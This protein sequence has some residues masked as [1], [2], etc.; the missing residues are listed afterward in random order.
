MHSSNGRSLVLTCA[1]LLLALSACPR[2]N[3]SPKQPTL[4]FQPQV[5]GTAESFAVLAGQAVTNTGPST[6]NGDVGVSPGTAVTGF[7]PG[8]VTGGTIHSADAVALQAQ[9]DATTAYNELA[10]RACNT[11]LSGQDLGGLTLTP[12]V[13]CFSSSAQLTGTLTL[14]A[15]GDPNAVFVF[16]I[17]STLTTA[18]N[19]TVVLI[20]G[21]VSCNVYWQVGSSGTLGTNTTF[22]GSSVALTSITLQTGARVTGH[23]LALNGSVTLDSNRVATETCNAPADG[24]GTSGATTASTTATS[25]TNATGATSTGSAATTGA[26]TSAAGTSTAGTTASTGSNQTGATA[27]SSTVG[28]TGTTGGTSTTGANSGTTSG[29]TTGAFDGGSGCAGLVC[30]CRCVD[31]SSDPTNCGACDHACARGETCTSGHC[32]PPCPGSTLRCGGTCVDP[33][34]DPANCG[35]CGNVCAAGAACAAGYCGTCPGTIC[36]SWCVDLGTDRNDCGHCGVACAADQT[37]TSATC[38]HCA[39][40]VCGNRCVDSATDPRNCGGCG[41]VCGFGVSCIG[42]SCDNSCPKP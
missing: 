42:G 36:G 8:L 16:Q 41:N 37:C 27:A 15:Q 11:T 10:G 32:G 6:I 40:T 24:G 23:V 20:N 34:T 13:Y 17:G 18:S 4:S 12:G 38:V 31:A 25:S 7:P 35:I 33:L 26:T 39:G 3:Q 22:V 14:N 9:S 5:L 1:G 19:S 2:R 30:G 29:G 21:G 28:A